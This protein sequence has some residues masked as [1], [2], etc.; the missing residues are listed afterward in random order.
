MKKITGL[1]FIAAAVLLL[2][3]SFQPLG[4]ELPRLAKF[5][6]QIQPFGE[7]LPR[8]AKVEYPIKPLGEELPRLA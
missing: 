6:S 4:E 2:G 7:E 3:S 8:L 5:D 1:F